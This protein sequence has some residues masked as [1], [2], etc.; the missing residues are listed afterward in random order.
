MAGN[1]AAAGHWGNTIVAA[2]DLGVPVTAKNAHCTIRCYGRPEHPEWEGA[3][4]V[5][6]VL[7]AAGCSNWLQKAKNFTEKL[8]KSPECG[9]VGL[10]RE[11]VIDIAFDGV[12]HTKK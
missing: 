7:A 9:G 1:G 6:D 12:C 10:C 3:V 4:P 8:F 11:D 2:E 5:N